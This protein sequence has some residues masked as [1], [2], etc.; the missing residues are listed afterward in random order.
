MAKNL[1]TIFFLILIDFKFRLDFFPI[2]KAK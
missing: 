1:I 2:I